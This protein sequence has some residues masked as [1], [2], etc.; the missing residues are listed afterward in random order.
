LVASRLPFRSVSS[1][2]QLLF[3]L[4]LAFE[5]VPS[6]VQVRGRL[7]GFLPVAGLFSRPA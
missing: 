2:L 6:V 5:T 3:R 1:A 4:A 7:V